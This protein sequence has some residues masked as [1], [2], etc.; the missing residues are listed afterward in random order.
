MAASA[1]EVSST[2]SFSESD[3]I[4]K[5]SAVLGGGLSTLRL[6]RVRTGFVL[7]ATASGQAA[8]QEN[9]TR[10]SKKWVF[11]FQSPL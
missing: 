2:V 6:R 10:E 8:T 3:E 5:S 4:E 1:E 9:G 7:Y 11:Q